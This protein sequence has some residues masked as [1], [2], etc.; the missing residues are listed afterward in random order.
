MREKAN[1]ELMD[2]SEFLKARANSF[3][4]KDSLNPNIPNQKDYTKIRVSRM[5][6]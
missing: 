2:Y 5:T 6:D 4:M 1:L 3:F